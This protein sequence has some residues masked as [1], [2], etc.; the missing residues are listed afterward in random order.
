MEVGGLHSE[1]LIMEAGQLRGNGVDS[2]M[3][4]RFIRNYN[5]M[6]VYQMKKL[7]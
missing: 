6:V 7:L 3:E 4:L 5:K 1:K 2:V